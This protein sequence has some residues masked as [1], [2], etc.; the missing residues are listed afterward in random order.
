[1]ITRSGASVQRP[2]QSDSE[3]QSSDDPELPKPPK[4]KAKLAGEPP[5]PPKKK[6]RQPQK[7]AA[8]ARAR[9][10]AKMLAQVQATA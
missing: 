5:K 9:N 4:K 10:E 1:M 3:A 7:T 8:Q 6:L 2:H